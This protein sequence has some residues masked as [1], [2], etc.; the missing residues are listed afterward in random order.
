MIRASHILE[1]ISAVLFEAITP[2]TIDKWE[3]EYFNFALAAPRIRDAMD[4]K[5]VTESFGKWID[6]FISF[7][8]QNLL[9]LD[10]KSKNYLRHEPYI[11]ESIDQLRNEF[12]A[13]LFPVNLGEFLI[14]HK[15][16]KEFS[17]F[18]EDFLDDFGGGTYRILGSTESL[19]WDVFFPAWSAALERGHLPFIYYQEMGQQLFKTIRYD[20]QKDGTVYDA[21]REEIATIGSVKVFTYQAEDNEAQSEELKQ[22]VSGLKIALGKLRNHGFEKA[23]AGAK[24]VLDRQDDE[25]ER[26]EETRN[27]A[28]QYT[29]STDTIE[30]WYV[31]P[32][33]VGDFVHEF[34]HR[35]YRRVM[36]QRQQKAW[37]D[38]C[39]KNVVEIRPRDIDE[40]LAGLEAFGKT[41]NVLS[42][43]E[44]LNGWK[45]QLEKSGVGEAL[46]EKFVALGTY[47]EGILIHLYHD[48]EN[49]K[50]DVV[51]TIKKQLIQRYPSGVQL[52]KHPISHYGASTG[53]VETY[54]E[55]FRLYC[56]DK[57]ISEIV[58][59]EF[60]R[61]SGLT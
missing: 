39:I 58:E 15:N 43:E 53:E 23:T 41:F 32:Q 35:Y 10:T 28:A 21:H 61:I 6:S 14:A 2:E 8:K 29:H 22:L 25:H 49:I 44:L 4:L 45:Q 57:P 50:P 54:A 48:P 5:E 18:I 46:I 40:M 38:F 31:R 55:V 19:D 1:Q 52:F 20:I 13:S 16:T 56:E 12:R 51:W 3:R 47:I 30:V 26:S 34:A 37:L 60:E 59:V 33:T 7:L 24:V 36:S 42:R 9:G 11:K 27:S 17:H